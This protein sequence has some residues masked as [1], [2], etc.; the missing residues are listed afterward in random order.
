MRE[1]EDF[2]EIEGT[3]NKSDKEKRHSYLSFVNLRR[4]L[5][6]ILNQFSVSLN[7]SK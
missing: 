7:G 5:V 2:R 3:L 4:M 6:F 1:F